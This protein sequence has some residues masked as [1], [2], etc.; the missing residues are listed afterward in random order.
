MP[1]LR[2]ERDGQRSEELCFTQSNEVT[3]GLLP[4]ILGKLDPL[5]VFAMFDGDVMLATELALFLRVVHTCPHTTHGF[6]EVRVRRRKPVAVFPGRRLPSKQLFEEGAEL[7][8]DLPMFGQRFVNWILHSSRRQ[9]WI[10][11]SFRGPFVI[12][13]CWLH[14]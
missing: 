9:A 12:A 1:E 4:R 2:V 11:S 6:S 3:K 10:E 14:V 13:E 5:T 8:F 7:G